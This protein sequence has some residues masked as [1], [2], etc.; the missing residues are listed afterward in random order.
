[1]CLS[2][3]EMQKSKPSKLKATDRKK[4]RRRR[5]VAIVAIERGKYNNNVDKCQCHVTHANWLI[6]LF[7]KERMPSVALL[8]CETCVI[9][10]YYVY[11]HVYVFCL[12]VNRSKH[13]SA[14]L[15]S[16]FH[17]SCFNARSVEYFVWLCLSH[18]I[19]SHSQAHIHFYR[20]Y[21]FA[22][23]FMLNRTHTHTSSS[24]WIAQ[25]A[26]V[27]LQFSFPSRNTKTK[28][29]SFVLDRLKI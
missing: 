3:E 2:G 23:T 13:K 11:L 21:L 22:A 4:K 26:H 7:A 5:I 16:L 12:N 27:G 14:R 25:S 6:H 28:T 29:E 17:S 19:L 15:I 24:T 18:L 9:C 8:L 1:M 10:L 20:K